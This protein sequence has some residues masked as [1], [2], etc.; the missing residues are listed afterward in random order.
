MTDDDI[1]AVV[2]AAIARHVTADATMPSRPAPAGIDAI[3]GTDSDQRHASHG[4]FV[5][6]RA[7]ADSSCLIEPAVRCTHC[8]YCQSYGH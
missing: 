4:R 6:D 3:P 1:R 2:R 7:D 8:G 5:L